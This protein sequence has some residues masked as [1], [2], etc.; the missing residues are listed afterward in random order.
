MKE[1]SME[2]LEKI[3]DCIETVNLNDGD[4]WNGIQADLEN[5]VSRMGVEIPLVVE[6][7]TLC[8]EGIRRLSEKS[9]TSPLLL[10]DAISECLYGFQ[11]CLSGDSDVEDLMAKRVGNWQRF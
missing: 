11:E 9:V 6:P 2:T 4:A 8:L 3:I 5:L 1:K 7:L 10:V